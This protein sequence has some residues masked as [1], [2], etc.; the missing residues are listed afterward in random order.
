[1]RKGKSE[2]LFISMGGEEAV[3]LGACSA[4]RP[5]NY[6]TSTHRG[7]GYCIAKG[8]DIK[9]MIAELLDKDTGYCHGL[10]GSMHIANEE[11]A[12]LGATGIVGSGVPIA[13][14]AGLGCKL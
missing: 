8:A 2:G 1:M 13:M 5:D 10:G 7:H 6:I 4:L 9:K 12:N 14:G 3:A 11:K